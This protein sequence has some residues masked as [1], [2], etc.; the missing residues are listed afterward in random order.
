[1]KLS[2]IIPIY[3]EEENINELFREIRNAVAPLGLAFE[4]LAINDGSSDKSLEVARNASRGENNFK[5]IDFKKNYGQTAALSAG[6]DAAQGGIIIALDGDGQNDPADIPRLIEKMEEGYDVVSGWRKDRKDALILRKIPS[7][8]AN[9]LI[10]LITE[11]YLH[12][13]G[14]TLKA[15]K[16]EVVKELHLYGEMHRFIPAYAYWDGARV[17]EIIVNHRP[18]KFGKTKYGIGRTLRVV[19]DLLTV[20]FLTRYTTRPMHFFGWVSFVL[21]SFALAS[22]VLAIYLRLAGIAT[23]IQTPLPLMGAFFSMA[24]LQFVLMGLI[25][26]MIMRNSFEGQ[27]KTV[28]Q[29]KEKINFN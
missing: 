13:Y 7:W 28:Y 27:K 11:V 22:F 17:A 3:N 2:I 18:R 19:L 10:S 16:K 29:I 9:Y 23:L 12:D 8:I 26:E 5:I 15:Y 4:V 24:S 25:A 1:M 14:C 21:M 20:K 6:F